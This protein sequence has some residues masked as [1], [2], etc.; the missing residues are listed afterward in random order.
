MVWRVCVYLVSD[1]MDSCVVRT[2]QRMQSFDL[3][4]DEELRNLAKSKLGGRDYTD[5]T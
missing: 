1:C 5:L 2:R 4:G 3:Q